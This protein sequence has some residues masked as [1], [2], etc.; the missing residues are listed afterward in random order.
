MNRLFGSSATKKP[1]PNLQDAINSTDTRMASIEVKIRKLDGELGRY[2]EQMAKLRNG[3]GKNAIQERAL[4]TLKQ[5]RM[6]EAQIAQ[7][8]QQTFNM[9]SAA[10][11]TDNLRNT[12]ATVDAMQLANKE[13]RKQYGKIDIDKIENIHYDMEDLLEQANEIQETLG[14]S[15]AVPD[16]IDE[17]DLEAE[18]DALALEEEEEGPSYLADLNKVPDFIDEAPVEMGET[19]A[20]QEAIKQTS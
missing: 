9:E 16:E 11:A 20:R 7:L 15:Y 3:P 12:M 4:R 19:P 2:K 6:Y 8:T 5:K 1:K 17:A 14:R 10:L 18:L 13:M